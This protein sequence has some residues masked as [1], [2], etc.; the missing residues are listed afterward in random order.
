M[1]ALSLPLGLACCCRLSHELSRPLP[2]LAL[3]CAGQILQQQGHPAWT[4][5]F[6]RSGFVDVAIDGC[7]LDTLGARQ[8]F[9][10]TALLRAPASMAGAQVGSGHTLLGT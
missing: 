4:L 2:S 9:G 5:Y 3:S 10:E 6:L 8:H 7:L 1:A